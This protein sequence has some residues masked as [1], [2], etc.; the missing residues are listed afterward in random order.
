MSGDE[1]RLS[2]EETSSEEE[3]S[4]SDSEPEVEQPTPLET[5]Q[6]L[7]DVTQ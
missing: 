1:E 2:V 3:S 4:A 7:P 5:N 6:P